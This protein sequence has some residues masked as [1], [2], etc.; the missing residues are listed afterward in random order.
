MLR[1]SAYTLLAAGLASQ[2]Q[3]EVLLQPYQP[4]FMQMS[5]PNVS[6]FSL[7][8]VVGYSPTQQ[9]CGGG[10]SCAGA[11]G[12][13]FEQCASNDGLEHCYNTFESQACCPGGRG[14]ESQIAT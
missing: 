12:N 7:D 2:T 6:A 11:C 14:G 3:A 1:S 5:A 8:G 13:G 9:Q 4:K 10:D